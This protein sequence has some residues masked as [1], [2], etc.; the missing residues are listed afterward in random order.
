MLSVEDNNTYV[1]IILFEVPQD[2]HEI[3]KNMYCNVFLRKA[4][5]VYRKSVSNLSLFVYIF[6]RETRISSSSFPVSGSVLKSSPLHF[7]H[8]ISS[9][10]DRREH[11]STFPS[12]SHARTHSPHVVNFNLAV[13]SWR[14]R[15][16]EV[17][18]PCVAAVFCSLD[19]NSACQCKLFG[20]S[21]DFWSCCRYK[22]L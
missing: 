11:S 21:T 4:Y 2:L 15:E 16:R 12:L 14:E 13:K 19:I 20:T 18:V 17:G 8:S 6:D 9:F 1:Y 5:T 3:R 22:V 7:F 10:S